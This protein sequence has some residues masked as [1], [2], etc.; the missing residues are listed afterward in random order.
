MHVFLVREL[1]NEMKENAPGLLM[2]TDDKEDG[3]Y[4]HHFHQ[5]LCQ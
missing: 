1:Y 2:S 4:L 3:R 5:D